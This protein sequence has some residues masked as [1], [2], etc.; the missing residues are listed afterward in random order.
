M[1]G[2]YNK[3]KGLIA[4]FFNVWEAENYGWTLIEEGYIKD[5]YVEKV[6]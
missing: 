1:I 4:A 5:F 6:L 3:E 2:V